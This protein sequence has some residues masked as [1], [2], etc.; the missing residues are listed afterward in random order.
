[1]AGP[2]PTWYD[3]LLVARPGGE[4]RQLQL[5]RPARAVLPVQVPERFGDLYGID[6]EIAAVLV[7]WQCPGSGRV[8][9]AVDDDVGDVHTCSE[10]SS[11]STCAKVRIMTL[12]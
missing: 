9:R 12:G 5:V 11:V 8:D 7:S 10:Y 2:A 1:M 3:G 4:R 6:D